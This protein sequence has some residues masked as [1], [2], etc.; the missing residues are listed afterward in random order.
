M[1]V[2]HVTQAAV[3]PLIAFENEMINM[4]ST[5]HLVFRKLASKSKAFL[6]AFRVVCCVADLEMLIKTN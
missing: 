3:A 6:F 4:I 2:G 5:L 1:A